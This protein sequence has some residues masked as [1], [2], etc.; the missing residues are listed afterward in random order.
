MLHT[1][2][3]SRPGRL[4]SVIPCRSFGLRPQVE[5]AKKN[6]PAALD[7]IAKEPRPVALVDHE[8]RMVAKSAAWPAA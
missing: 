4:L 8:G 6:A 1:I 7:L 3:A 5:F 2:R